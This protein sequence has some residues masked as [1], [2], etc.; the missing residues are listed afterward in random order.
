MKRMT[1]RIEGDHVVC[2]FGATAENVLEKT[3]E[4][5]DRLAEYEDTGL[6]PEDIQDFMERW[7]TAA[8]IAGLV[9]RYGA[10]RLCKLVQVEENGQLERKKKDMTES[11]LDLVREERTRQD[12]LWGDQSGNHL[13]EWV[14]ILGE[15]YGE[16]CEAVNETCSRAVR[17]PDR[18][19][20]EAVIKEAVHVAAV[21][22]A[23]IEAVSR[24]KQNREK[25][26]QN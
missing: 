16:L 3:Q 19:G 5:C 24:N 1:Y 14:S 12:S 23:I 26:N 8:E 10:D 21:A 25:E 17:H 20:P 4:I 15:E 18:G 7:K 2:V 22:V 13:F 11:A 9:K 6:E